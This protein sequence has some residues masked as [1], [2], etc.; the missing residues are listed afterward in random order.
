MLKKMY[1]FLGE[2]PLA[3]IKASFIG[4][5][6]PESAIDDGG[7]ICENLLNYFIISDLEK[8]K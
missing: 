5:S 4:C 3:P 8:A 7:L 2:I 6:A 1:I